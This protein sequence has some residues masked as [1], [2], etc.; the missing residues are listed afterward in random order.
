LATYSGN[1][2][3]PNW[4][5]ENPIDWWNGFCTCLRIIGERSNLKQI[6]ALSFFGQM[7]GLEILDENDEVIRPAI[8]WNDGRTTEECMILNKLPVVEWNGNIALAGFTAPKLEW[9]KKHESQN[10]PEKAKLCN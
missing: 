2:P 8:L 1:F 9:V 4:S 10:F 3:Q 5:E 6:E 7:L